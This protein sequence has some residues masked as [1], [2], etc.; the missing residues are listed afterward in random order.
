[1]DWFR[2]STY[3]LDND[4]FWEIMKKLSLY[5]F[6]VLMWCNVGI[7]ETISLMDIKIGDKIS[8]HF[9]SQQISKY[10]ISDAGK[11]PTGERLFGKDLKYSFIAIINE[12]GIFSEVYNFFQIYYENDSKKVVSISGTD[13]SLDKD[14]CLKKRNNKVSEY[15]SKNRITT[16]FNK[17]ETT[18]AYPDGTTTYDVAFHGPN[19]I[20]AFSCYVYTPDMD[21]DVEYSLTIYDNIYNIFIYEANNK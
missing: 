11:S 4:G 2:Y 6:L 15:K 19:K 3:W 13:F 7:A 5:I 8:K 21:K 1:M 18:N 16:L 20:F 10:Y 9:N 14:T 12:D 17:H